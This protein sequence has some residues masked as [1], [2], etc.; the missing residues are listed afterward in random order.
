[1]GKPQGLFLDRPPPRLRPPG[2]GTPCRCRCHCR[3]A[4]ITRSPCRRTGD[5]M[6]GGLRRQN[7]PG[8]RL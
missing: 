3:P 4:R 6:P 2:G 5:S 7:S 1:V 8:Q